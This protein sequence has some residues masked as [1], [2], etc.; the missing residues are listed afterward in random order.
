MLLVVVIHTHGYCTPLGFYLQTQH[1][2]ATK[3]E[4][5]RVWGFE[6]YYQCSSSCS[7]FALSF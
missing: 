7:T 2:W 5:S 4:T 1:N 6:S 3:S